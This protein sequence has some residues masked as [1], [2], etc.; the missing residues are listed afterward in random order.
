VNAI[1]LWTG[2]KDSYLALRSVRARG[3]QVRGLVTF[4]PERA[5]FLAHPLPFIRLQAA[6]LGIEHRVYTVVE[7][8]HANYELQL[9]AALRDFGADTVVTG[10]IAEVAG[11]PNLIAEICDRI[12]AAC[13]RPLWER[14]R[15]DLL[16]EL[17]T[18]GAE[19]VISC[20]RNDLLPISWL[21]RTLDPNAIAEL[22]RAGID[23][24][25]EN[26][27]YHTLVGD[28]P[29]MSSRIAI[30]GWQVAHR[31]TLAYFGAPQ[32]AALAKVA[33]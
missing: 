1:I 30:S 7:P 20:L 19:A 23:P 17:Q 13:Q 18:S 9:A 4:A 12:G 3:Y 26:G 15:V 14:A 33:A 11:H 32:F 25:G 24:C 31:D 8:H 29:E 5:E 27:E 28:A 2:G 6:A 21:G 22:Q 16:A 10:D